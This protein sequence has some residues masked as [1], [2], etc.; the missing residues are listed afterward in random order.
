VR[1]D[2]TTANVLGASRWVGN[3]ESMRGR[4]PGDLDARGRSDGDAHHTYRS[5]SDFVRSVAGDCQTAS[6]E[7]KDVTAPADQFVDLAKR[8]QDA[9]AGFTKVWADSVQTFA[10]KT[11]PNGAGL[12]D[13]QSYLDS[14][15][16][17]AD[18][19]LAHQREL[20]LQFVGAASRATSVVAEQAR[21]LAAQAANGTNHS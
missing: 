2:L 5:R 18:K 17:F 6:W 8:G 15:F 20:T 3:V 1:F 7:D 13:V 12:P 9:V 10:D 4:H 19:V 21:T 16:D 14:Y 11:T